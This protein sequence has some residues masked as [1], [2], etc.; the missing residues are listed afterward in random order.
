MQRGSFAPASRPAPAALTALL[1]LV[2]AALLAAPRA[3]WA[4]STVLRT[5]PGDGSTVNAPPDRISLVFNEPVWTDYATVVVTGSDGR[6]LQT[7]PPQVIETTLTVPLR[8]ATP[9]GYHVTWRVVSADGHPITGEFSFTATAA[10]PAASTTAT[11][12]AG[13]ATSA[14]ASASAP[15][16]APVSTSVAAGAAAT[17]PPAQPAPPKEGEDWW[18]IG[19]LIA[20]LVALGGAYVVFRRRKRE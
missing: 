14:S 6:T 7:G 20:A 8:G 4:H 16:S 19:L 10:G 18:I 9:G 5:E 13:P 12:T 2:L 3:A 15:A 11:A 17:T 1:L